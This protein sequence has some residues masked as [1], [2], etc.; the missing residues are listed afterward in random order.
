MKAIHQVVRWVCLGGVLALGAVTAQAQAVD[1]AAA[2]AMLKTN[3]CTKCHSID[4]KK[5][6]PSY[7]SVAAKYKGKGDAQAKLVTHMTT[8]PM[9]EVDGEKEEHVKA[10][11]DAAAVKNLANF[12]L[13]Q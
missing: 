13:A 7:K 11:G 10:K 8:G 12:I 4:K 5:T 3:K 6:G 1:A 2:E 9:V